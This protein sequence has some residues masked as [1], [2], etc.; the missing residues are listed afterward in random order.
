MERLFPKLDHYPRGV[1]VKKGVEI[2]VTEKEAAGLL[3][4]MNGSTQYCFEEI[5]KREPKIIEEQEE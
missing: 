3:T 1:V 5:K 2:K 4:M